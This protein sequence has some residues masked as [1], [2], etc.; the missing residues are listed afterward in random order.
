MPE[1]YMKRHISKATTTSAIIRIPTEN[2]IAYTWLYTAEVKTV[3]IGLV[4]QNIIYTIIFTSL[5]ATVHT[6]LLIHQAK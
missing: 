2:I 5:T 3:P 1:S 4:L 6:T